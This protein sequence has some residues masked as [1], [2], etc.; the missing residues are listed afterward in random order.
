MN[1]VKQVQLRETAKKAKFSRV[2]IT[3][4]VQQSINLINVLPN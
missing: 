1:H 2:I 3:V 4:S